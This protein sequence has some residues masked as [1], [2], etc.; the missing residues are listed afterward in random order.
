M[1]NQ[2][3]DLEFDWFGIDKNHQVAIFS[4]FNRGY[5]PRDFFNSLGEFQKLQ[6]IINSLSLNSQAKQITKY[7]GD[8]SDWLRY[9]T[10]G[11]YAYDYQDIHRSTKMNEY[12]I[13]SIPEKPLLLL[14]NLELKNMMPVL[15]KFNLIFGEN[16]SFENLKQSLI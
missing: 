6:S 4:T 2:S 13:I 16:I 1:L 5:I 14:E 10:K 11:L 3:Y 8:F 12:D 9:S 15:P 7:V